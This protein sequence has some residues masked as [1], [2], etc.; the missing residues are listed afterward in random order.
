[1]QEVRRKIVNALM[2]NHAI[3]D[4]WVDVLRKTY[5]RLTNAHT[6]NFTREMSAPTGEKFQVRV[7]DEIMG[8]RVWY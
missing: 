1:M 2:N 8:L 4:G 7:K 3:E 6:I 5:A